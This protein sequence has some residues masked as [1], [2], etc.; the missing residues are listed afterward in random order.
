M[1]QETKALAPDLNQGAYISLRD[2][3]MLF[4]A[5]AAGAYLAARLAPLWLVE[6]SHTL[7]GPKPR[8]FWYL[9]RSSAFV[10]YVLL[11]LSIMLG[12]MM[13]SK[14]SRLWPGGP[15]A[16]DL[17]Q[18][19]SMMGLLFA[20]FHAFV[21]MG[22]RF[23]HYD[24]LDVLLPFH[25][26][27]YRTLWVGLGQLGLYGML[28]VG[29]SFYLRPRLSQRVWRTLHYLSFLV[30][31][32]V[33][34]H[35]L[36]TGS[37]TG[38]WLARAMYGFT[39]FSV[40]CLTVHR[41][42]ARLSSPQPQPFVIQEEAASPLE[43]PAA[44]PHAAQLSTPADSPVALVYG[45]QSGHTENMAQ[46]AAGGLST[47]GVS[48][49]LIDAQAFSVEQLQHTQRLIVMTSTT[50]DGEPPDNLLR[51]YQQLHQA[52]PNLAHL[53][54]AVL[55]CG[56]R[57]Y[58]HF[59]KAGKDI[60]ARLAVLGAQ[61]LC[62]VA[63][64]DANDESAFPTWLSSMMRIVGTMSSA[65]PSA[66]AVPALLIQTPHERYS[67]IQP[68][69]ATL[70]RNANLINDTNAE[71]QTRHIV[72]SLR[73]SGL[74]YEPGDALGVM[75][76]NPLE[77]VVEIINAAGLYKDSPVPTPSGG[78][79]PLCDAL[80]RRYDITRI[81]RAYVVYV[82]EHTGDAALLDLLRPERSDALKQYLHGRE[83]RDLLQQ[84]RPAFA[85]A[86]E[87]VGLLGKLTPRL[88]SISSSLRMHPDEV[89]LTVGVLRYESHGQPRHGVCSNDLA[90]APAGAVKP[91]FIH[92]NKT[93]RLPSDPAT[94]LI[95]IGPGTGIAPFRSFLQERAASG[96]TTGRNWLFFGCQ[97]ADTD[98]L[99][100]DE[101]ERFKARGIL[102][103]LDV[104]FSRQQSEKV[105][106]QHL[107]Q[108]HA[109][110]LWRWLQEGAHLYVCGDAARMARDVDAALHEVAMHAGG[111]GSE[112]AHAWVD[113]LRQQKRYRRDVY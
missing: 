77:Q 21:L 97:R 26:D 102:K 3:L 32:L 49:N 38:S 96:T 40:I 15:V 88:Y 2:W 10:S 70:L 30:F 103:R 99:Y 39:S 57:Q 79:L 36:L 72:F 87:F 45:S 73:D 35:G 17:H 47:A 46:H 8:V 106:V 84:H 48:V 50:G 28:L 60:D 33:L 85:S 16:F 71:R 92:P 34:A 25:S 56:D 69:P 75:P 63:L 108:Q 54:Y 83:L 7:A 101:L 37:D 20:A 66:P 44:T 90:A 18:S 14:V 64:C 91:I 98:F 100:R 81:T 111:L 6:L 11:W 78:E 13:T 1:T 86:I 5:V 61:R 31:I 110:E 42:L 93:F 19:L 51:F 82:A 68:Y 80:L 52:T 112:Q 53:H 4:V 113:E 74:S 89:H 94:S 59:C 41:I 105:Y 43:L 27:A 12:L 55:A 65:Q 107:M 109:T 67:R 76:S 58:T 22:S 95:M 23:L 9:G 24:V 62:E 104:A 29:F